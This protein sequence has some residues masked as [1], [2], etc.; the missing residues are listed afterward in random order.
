MIQ[1]NFN[2]ITKADIDFLID[3]KISEVKTLEYKEKLP[4]SQDSDKKEFLAD[5]SSFAN[6]SGGDIIYGIKAAV[7]Q[8]GKKTGEP[9]RVVP[10]QGITGDEAKLQIEN[11]I[12]SG[13][14]PRIRVC[15]L[16]CVNGLNVLNSRLPL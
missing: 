12:R 11:L 6:S 13:I 9:E 2:E 14:E 4:G 5:I 1:K 15:S 7:N 8:D 3:N 16:N 10:I